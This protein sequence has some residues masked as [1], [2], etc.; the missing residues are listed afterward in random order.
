MFDAKRSGRAPRGKKNP[1]PRYKGGDFRPPAWPLSGR[2]NPA[3]Q[4][5]QAMPLKS[6]NVISL[7]WFT[8][9]STITLSVSELKA[10]EAS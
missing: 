2:G 4:G 3:A 9:V 5:Y 7:A 1:H 8:P 6:V 10:P